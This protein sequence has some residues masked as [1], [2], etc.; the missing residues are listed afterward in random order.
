M[1]AACTYAADPSVI[2]RPQH[3]LSQFASLCDRKPDGTPGAIEVSI[4]DVDHYPDALA[5]IADAIV[6][7]ASFPG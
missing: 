2:G 3:R 7:S 6:R 1:G 5:T 4:C